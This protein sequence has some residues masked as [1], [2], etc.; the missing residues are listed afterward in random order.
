MMVGLYL[1]LMA[2]FTRRHR[3]K[4]RTVDFTHFEQWAEVEVEDPNYF[5]VGPH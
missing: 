5:I 1:G 3:V 4:P 2:L